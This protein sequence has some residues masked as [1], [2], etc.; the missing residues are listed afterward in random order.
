MARNDL[1]ENEEQMVVRYLEKLR[2]QIQDALRLHILWTIKEVYYRAVVAEEQLQRRPTPRSD[3]P[4]WS[5]QAMENQRDMRCNTTNPPVHIA[6]TR[7]SNSTMTRSSNPWCYN[8]GEIGHTWNNCKKSVGWPEKQLL[9]E[10]EKPFEEEQ[11][12]VYDQTDNEEDDFLLFDDSEEAL[13][14]RKNLLAPKRERKEDW[15]WINIFYIYC[16]IE[17]RVCKIIIDDR[18]CENV[19]SQEA[20]KKLNLLTEK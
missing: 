8:Y 15:R 19:I 12:P 4:Q 7:S 3:P 18:S 1:T 16:T 14:I 17:K 5:N 10:E 20:I 6:D 9:I 11:Q 13:V 2:L